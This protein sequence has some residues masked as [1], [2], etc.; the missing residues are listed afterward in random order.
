VPYSGPVRIRVDKGVYKALTGS[1]K[2]FLMKAFLIP[3]GDDPEKESKDERKEVKQ[4]QRQAAKK[5]AEQKIAGT[6]EQSKQIAD[7]KKA[8]ELALFYT[9]PAEF[10][11]HFA[12]IYGT[13]EM[14]KANKEAW[15]TTAPGATSSTPSRFQR[16]RWTISNTFSS[17]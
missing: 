2:Y 8:G 13:E 5:V 16:T 10:N 15:C 3:T 11:G 12:L 1:E 14:L 7:S 4:E 9:F 6:F 17:N